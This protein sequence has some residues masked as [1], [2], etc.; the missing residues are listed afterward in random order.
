MKKIVITQSNY[1]PWKG[2]FDMLN[3][4]DVFVVYDDM[5]YTKRDWRNRNLIKT[6][7]GLS[8]L[9]VP[10]SVKGKYFQKISET[11]ISDQKWTDK[12]WN[13][14]K[15]NYSKSMFYKEICSLIEPLYARQYKTI[16]EV[17]V[18][19]IKVI[20]GYLQI[21]TD[22][23]YSSEFTLAEERSQ[24]LLDI[25][26]ELNGRKYI[27]GPSAEAY[28]DQKLFSE[29]GVEVEWFNFA[30]YPEYDQLHGQFEHGVTILDV[31][32][33]TGHDA[34]KYLKPT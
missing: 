18:A 32:F 28:L 24:R 22:I 12:H 31:L 7:N 34:M 13:T 25:C 23:R 10:V 20:C 29:N 15:H 21:D 14:I 19:F 33:N 4:A 27:S 17:N 30:D 26:L 5:Q 11:E 2:Y 8:W 16:T 3:A 1:I 6:P 9:S